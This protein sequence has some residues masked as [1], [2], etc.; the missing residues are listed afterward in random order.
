MYQDK[1]ESY[2]SNCRDEML[3]L[4]P[5]LGNYRILEIGAG[6]GETL[7][8]AKETGLGCYVVGV[9]LVKTENGSQSHPAIDR[10]LI[11]DIETL[12]GALEENFYDIILCGDVLEHLVDPWHCLAKLKLLLREGGLVIASIPN[13]RYWK[14]SMGLL[15]GGRWQ[16]GDG[17]ILDASHLRYFVR[18]TVEDLFQGAG[19]QIRHLGQTGPQRKW[20]LAAWGV[21]A[22]TLGYFSDLLTVQYLVVAAKGTGG[23]PG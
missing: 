9:D 18:S 7:V 19:F 1:Q 20:G 2:F 10:F 17:G 15:F 21:N 4:I 14:V 3:V 13:V 8:K 16:Y 11:G 5:A 6:S 23:A 12:D 22:L